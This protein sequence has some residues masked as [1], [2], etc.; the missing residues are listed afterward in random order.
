MLNRRK[1]L[2]AA[3]GL[4][5][6]GY[7]LNRPS[8]LEAAPQAATEFGRVKIVDLKTASLRVR[9]PAHLVKV[10]TDS[11][12]HGIGEAYNRAGIVEHIEAIKRQV[13]GED[14]LQVDYLYQKMCEAGVGQGSRAGS[15][16]GAISGIET[17]LYY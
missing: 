17:A 11:G 1:L 12:F 6:A 7:L 2:S 13:I 9:Y 4:A 3:G 15:L 14:P 8:V 10:I 5:A 16:S